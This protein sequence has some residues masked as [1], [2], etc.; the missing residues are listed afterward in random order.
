M[1]AH[2]PKE[3][4]NTLICGEANGNRV[5]VKSMF[6]LVSGPIPLRA[7]DGLA[8][9]WAYHSQGGVGPPT[10]ANMLFTLTLYL[11]AAPQRSVSSTSLVGMGSHVPPPPP[12][13]LPAALIFL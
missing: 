11:F 9:F 12:V 8:T 10:R 6:Y 3:V 1:G 4:N 2:P 5:R 7:S 13:L